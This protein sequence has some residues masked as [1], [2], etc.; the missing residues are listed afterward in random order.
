MATRLT[1]F[2]APGVCLCSSVG[3]GL[4]A[5]YVLRPWLENAAV[6]GIIF[7]WKSMEIC[8]E[9]E[10]GLLLRVLS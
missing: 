2:R 4:L 5:R 8:L 1:S 3:S 7:I 6:L 9:E 10:S